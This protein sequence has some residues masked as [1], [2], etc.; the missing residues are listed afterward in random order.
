MRV[1]RNTYRIESSRRNIN[2]VVDVVVSYN[3]LSDA[4]SLVYGTVCPSRSCEVMLKY[5]TV[6]LSTGSAS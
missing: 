4:I 6:I 2:F 5:D 3:Q 1:S